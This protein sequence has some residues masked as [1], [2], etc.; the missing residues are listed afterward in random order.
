MYLFGNRL[1]PFAHRAWF[2]LHEKGAA[3]EVTYIHVDL[4][5]AKPPWFG[6][7]IN[8]RFGTVPCMVDHGAGVFESPIVVEFLD[9]KFAGR[10]TA[11][12]PTG[13]PAHARRRARERAAR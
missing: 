12:M 10:G 6:D 1:C 7:V 5:D 11:L 2:A 8:P 13:A 3:E 4:G 9:E